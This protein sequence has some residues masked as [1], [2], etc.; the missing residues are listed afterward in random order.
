[1]GSG[2]TWRTPN[3]NS[4]VIAILKERLVAVYAVGIEAREAFV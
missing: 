1:M 4:A 3:Q 2:R